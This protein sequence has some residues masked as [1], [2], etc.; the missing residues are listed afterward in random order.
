MSNEKTKSMHEVEDRVAELLDELSALCEENH[1]G[2][3]ALCVRGLPVQEAFK[4]GMMQ[5]ARLLAEL[6]ASAEFNSDTRSYVNIENMRSS[7]A[8]SLGLIKAFTGTKIRMADDL[9]EMYVEE[10]LGN[11]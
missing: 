4:M 3:F 6:E 5:G 2:A 9:E 8:F 1:I 10:C 11:A 7:A